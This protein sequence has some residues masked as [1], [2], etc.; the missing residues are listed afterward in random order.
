MAKTLSEEEI[1]LRKRARRRLV[2]AIVL[3]TAAVVVLPMILDS[4]PDRRGHEIDIHIPSEDSVEELAAESVSPAN[5]PLATASSMPQAEGSQQAGAASGKNITALPPRETLASINEKTSAS[6][7]PAAPR[8]ETAATSTAPAASRVETASKNALP[9]APRNE[10]A[11]TNTAPATSRAETASKNAAPAASREASF[12]VQ[13]GAFSTPTKA[14][15]QSEKVASQNFSAYTEIVKSG[16]EEVT[17]VRV[18][19][20]ATREEADKT[21]EKLKNLGFEGVVTEK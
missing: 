1:Q 11:P 6:P 4:K 21:R 10:R 14:A 5:T 3:A 12:V 13:L 9:A 16:K 17:R 18:G 19:P 20:F 7:A 8:N 15:R 2:G